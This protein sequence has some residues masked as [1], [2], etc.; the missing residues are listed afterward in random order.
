VVHLAPRSSGRRRLDLIVGGLLAV[1]GIVVAVV[2]VIALGQPKGHQS[3]KAAATTPVSAT[4]SKPASSTPASSSAAPSTS[5]SSS[6]ASKSTSASSKASASTAGTGVKATPLIVLNSTSQSGLAAS[7]AK[8]FANGGWTITSSGNIVNN[9]LSTC[10]YYDPSD[11]SNEV[12]AQALMSQ[13]PAIKRVAVKFD[14][15]PAGP[16]VV[17]LTSDYS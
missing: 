5:A 15:L 16:V 4:S 1:L 2:A 17:V 12:A 7:A 6:T 3:A 14:G 11:P 9:I 10:A 13:F 8:T